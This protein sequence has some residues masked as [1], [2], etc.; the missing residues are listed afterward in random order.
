[1]KKYIIYA[2]N[3]EATVNIPDFSTKFNTVMM[4]EVV[5][6]LMLEGGFNNDTVSC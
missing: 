4:F 1:M 6:P 5:S 2:M 3:Q